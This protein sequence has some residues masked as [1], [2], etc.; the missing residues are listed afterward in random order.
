M[1]DSDHTLILGYGEKVFAILRELC[2]ANKIRREPVIV[3]LSE[4]EKEKVENAVREYGSTGNTRVI[5]RQVC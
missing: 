3:I 5:V 4:V 2:E 1:I